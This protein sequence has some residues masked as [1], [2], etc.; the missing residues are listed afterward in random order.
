MKNWWFV[1]LGAFVIFGI[2]MTLRSLD[3]DEFDCPDE[4]PLDYSENQST[5][6]LVFSPACSHCTALKNYIHTKHNSVTVLA[7][8][9]GSVVAPILEG[10]NIEWGYGVPILFAKI[11]DE[12]IVLE[13]FPTGSQEEDGY[14]MGQEFEQGICTA[15]KGEAVFEEG[16]YKFCKLSTGMILGN[17]HAVD[18]VLERCENERCEFIQLDAE[19]TMCKPAY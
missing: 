9:K 10:F 16:N 1:L 2:A 13:G 19:T 6:F 4:I 15:Q 7:T 8:E 5:I 17:L 18:Y 11:G 3:Q 14:F 12:M